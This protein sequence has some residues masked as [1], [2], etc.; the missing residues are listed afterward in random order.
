VVLGLYITSRKK[1][2]SKHDLEGYARKSQAKHSVLKSGEGP[3]KMVFNELNILKEAGENPF[4]ANLRYAYQ[5][6]KHLFLVLDLALGG[7]LNFQRRERFKQKV[8]PPAIARFFMTEVF[9]G[10]QYLHSVN[11]IHRDLKP[12]NILLQEDGHIKITDF[13]ISVKLSEPGELITNRSGTERYMAPEMFKRAHGV[14]AD[15]WAFGICLFELLTGSCPCKSAEFMRSNPSLKAL[16]K[17]VSGEALKALESLAPAAPAEAAPAEAP[18]QEVQ[19][20]ETTSGLSA[21]PPPTSSNSAPVEPVDLM[22]LA[23]GLVTNVLDIDPSKRPTA[24]Q[25]QSHP[26][27]SHPS[28][29]S[30]SDGGSA[31]VHPAVDWEL[32]RQLQLPS[33]YVPDCTLANCVVNEQD[34]MSQ[35][36]V[37]DPGVD[38]PPSVTP[39]QDKAFEGY[40]HNTKME[41]VE[42][43][44]E[45]GSG[46]KG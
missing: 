44:G 39:E 20:A 35:L 17:K 3:L 13:G 1:K 23:F 10:L 31:G 33:L 24:T 34:I 27:F 38:E 32:A 29:S 18:A 42:P 12:E 43:D 25:I 36:G 22:A 8:F 15:W 9:L 16:K 26:F 46:R 11:I 19:P 21:S 40:E 6:Q 5:D 37:G 45:A 7:D 2:R 41:I 4:I 30:G 14:A 28:T